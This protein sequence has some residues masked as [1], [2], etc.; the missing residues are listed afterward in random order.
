MALHLGALAR[1]RGPG[2]FAQADMA[3]VN[4][5]IIA[6]T[7]KRTEQ[8]VIKVSWGGTGANEAIGDEMCEQEELRG[9][10]KRQVYQKRYYLGRTG[11]VKV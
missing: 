8:R 4:Q 5:F 6:D 11:R 10:T 1:Q 9:F 2:S 3:R 7:A